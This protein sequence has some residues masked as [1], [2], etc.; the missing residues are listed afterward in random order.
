MVAK[1][2]EDLTFIDDGMFQAVMHNPEVCA[3]VI[4]KLLHVQVK[5]IEYPELEKTI[6]PY[7]TSKSIRLDVYLK[8]E[9][10]VI[11]VEC[12]SYPMDA[13][14]KRTRYYQSMIDSDSLMK[15]QDYSEL[16]DSYIVFICKYDPFENSDKQPYR[17]PCY[18]FNNTCLENPDV[19]LND[20]CLK[21]IYN[22]MDYEKEKDEKLKAF[23]HYICTN[24][25]GEDEFSKRISALVEQI[26]Q[27]EKFRSDYNAMN[28]H[29]RDIT[30]KAKTEGLTEG[31]QEKAV[32]AALTLI[33]E[34]N[35]VPEIAA[36][37]MNAPLNKVLEAYNSVVAQR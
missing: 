9:D 30:R 36:K 26:K 17:L 19:D 7:Y 15:G 27:N 11:D 13:L 20:K 33:K 31:R 8:D 14:G 34:Y 6:A 29:E 3:E 5:K 18:T 24:E 25:P 28:L 1:K 10:K 32:E 37:K 16:K 2:I 12:Q 21:V 35:E 4:E 22:A 23:L